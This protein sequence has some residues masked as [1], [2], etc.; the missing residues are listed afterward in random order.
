M[1]E[2]TE[3]GTISIPFVNTRSVLWKLSFC[4]NSQNYSLKSPPFDFAGAS[5][6]FWLNAKE[7]PFNSFSSDKE[8]YFSLLLER[9]DSSIPHHGISYQVTLKCLEDQ[10]KNI[11]SSAYRCFSL[12][13]FDEDH[14]KHRMDITYHQWKTYELAKK[15]NAFKMSTRYSLE[16]FCILFNENSEKNKQALGNFNPASQMKHCGSDTGKF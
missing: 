15:H 9:V 5:W 11:T 8:F 1:A 3:T 10:S 7:D 2:N 6:C 12:E 13:T 16:L 14:K 4:I